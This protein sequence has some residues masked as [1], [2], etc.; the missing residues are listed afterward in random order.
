MHGVD[1]SGRM[2]ALRYAVADV[3]D[4]L[5]SIS[6]IC[7]AGNTVVFT[8]SG[9]YV[10]GPAGKTVFERSGDT[11]IRKMWVKRPRKRRPVAT[12]VDSD[13]D[14]QMGDGK[15]GKKDPER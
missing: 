14:V 3:T 2:L 6:Q 7:D 10:V 12:T 13:G 5:D 11:Y 15:G 9:G 8:S 1:G 4:A